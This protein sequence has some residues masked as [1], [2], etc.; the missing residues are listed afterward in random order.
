[1]R[2][3]SRRAMIRFFLMFV[4]P[5]AALVIGGHYWVKST[6]YVSTENAYVKAHHLAISADIDGRAT[7]VLVRENDRVKKGALLFELD[8]EQH[9]IDLA[10]S[11]AELNGIR[12]TLDALRAE[13]RTAQAELREG[14]QE[15]AY[16]KRVFDR[17]KKLMQRGVASCRW[18]T[19]AAVSRSSRIVSAGGSLRP[20]FLAWR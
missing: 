5:A 11:D 2:I 15:V 18:R 3:K 19:P 13:Y 8:P 10:R 4:V 6:R 1:M 20:P 12:N 9:R 16:Y 7:R 17:Q 14:Q